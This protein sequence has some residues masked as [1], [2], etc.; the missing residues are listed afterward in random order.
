MANALPVEIWNKIIEY[1]P[2]AHQ[3]DVLLVSRFFHDV[4]V[5]LLFSFIRIYFIGGDHAFT[6]LDTDDAQYTQ[7]TMELLM[8]RSWE[9]LNHIA[10]EPNF[11][12]V[13]R[14]I[15]V[16]AFT[17]DKTIFEQRK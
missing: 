6:M 8:H 7:E 14:S 11:A 13:V 16:H 3:R 10:Q 5:R 17:S 4:A 12:R 9:I 2:S 15:S 1:L